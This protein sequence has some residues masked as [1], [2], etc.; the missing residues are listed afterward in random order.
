MGKR[1]EDTLTTLAGRLSKLEQAITK[2][3]HKAIKEKS[4]KS[5]SNIVNDIFDSLDPD[6]IEALS[7][8]KNIDLED[9][10]EELIEIACT[11]FDDP[12]FRDLLETIKTDNEQMI[13]DI[14]VDEVLES[15]FDEASREKALGI[16]TSF[17]EYIEENKD[18]IDALSIIYNQSYATRHL[19]YEMIKELRA[20]F[21]ID[22]WLN[23][24]DQML[25]E[26]IQSVIKEY[27]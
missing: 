2:D 22:G 21:N 6:K 4:S 12:D 24:S 3:D 8:E 18:E 25:R 20:L 11:P 17:K 10:K 23:N 14:S 1:D 19:T 7:I 13:D 9:A 26:A 16:V 5:L 15:G 27:K